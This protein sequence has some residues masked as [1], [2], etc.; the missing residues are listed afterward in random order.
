MRPCR[1]L[2]RDYFGPG[3][4][5]SAI[6]VACA[7]IAAASAAGD[8]AEGHAGRAWRAEAR[9]RTILA[10]GRRLLGRSG[11]VTI[12]SVAIPLLLLPGSL[13]LLES[14]IARPLYVDRYVLY[15]EAGA[16]LLAGAGAYR[17]RPVAGGRRSPTIPHLGTGSGA[18]A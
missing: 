15:G 3:T 8:M 7:V 13:L 11:R 2:F 5:A 9:P 18:S 12:Q 10:A 17:V 6:L 16:A 14:V 4:A 1:T